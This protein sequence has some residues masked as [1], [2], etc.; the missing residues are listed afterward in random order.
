MNFTCSISWL[1]V[2]VASC[3]IL[4]ILINLKGSNV[5]KKIVTKF[6]GAGMRTLVKVGPIYLFIFIEM[7]VCLSVCPI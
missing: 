1:T 7:K 4:L 6:P 2:F 5:T 3:S